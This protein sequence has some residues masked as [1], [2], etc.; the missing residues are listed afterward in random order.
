LDD[1]KGLVRAEIRAAH[2]EMRAEFGEMRVVV[3]KKPL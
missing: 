2:G 3:E 1:V